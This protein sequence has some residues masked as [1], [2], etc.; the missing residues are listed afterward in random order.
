[1]L[2][3]HRHG[4]YPFDLAGHPATVSNPYFS[5]SDPTYGLTTNAYD[6][7]DRVTQ[8]TK[9]DGSISHVAYGV[10]T[11]VASSGNCTVATDEASKQRGACSDALGRLVEVDEP[12]GAAVQANF[13]ALMQQDGNFAL[14]T[15]AVRRCGPRHRRTNAH[16]IFMQDD[17]NLV[18]YIF[19]WQAGVYAAASP[20]PFPSSSCSIGTSCSGPDSAFREM[21]V[22]PH[23]Q[24]FLPTQYR[25]KLFHL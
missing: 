13:H 22:S 9:Q 14:P 2:P 7:L 5:T 25:W 8:T 15:L 16:T 11:S 4:R 3:W 6:G 18:T 12:S 19:K 24:N 20:G 23:G 10:L 1:M 21:L 17:G